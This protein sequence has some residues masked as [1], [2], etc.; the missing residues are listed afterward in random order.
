MTI[1]SRYSKDKL[2]SMRLMIYTW[3]VV[4]EKKK[5]KKEKKRVVVL[6]VCYNAYCVSLN[7]C[8]HLFRT[9]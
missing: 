5:K 1:S 8:H 4:K 6:Y 2:P 9:T 3:V 7:T